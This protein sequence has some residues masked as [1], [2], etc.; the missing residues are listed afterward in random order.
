MFTLFYDVFGRHSLEIPGRFSFFGR[1][2]FGS[3][4]KEF[5]DVS[6][7]PQE[8]NFFKKLIFFSLLNNYIRRFRICELR[9]P[10]IIFHSM[11][12]KEV[13]IP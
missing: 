11:D 3:R 8:K 4:E 9:K 5:S 1:Q 6:E 12:Y 2:R 13:T 7:H 10:I